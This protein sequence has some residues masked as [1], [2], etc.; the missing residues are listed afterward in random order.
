VSARAFTN[1]EL[2]DLLFYGIL[3]AGIGGLFVFLWLAQ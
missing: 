3:A 1:K 2:G